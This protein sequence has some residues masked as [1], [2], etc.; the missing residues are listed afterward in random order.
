[1]EKITPKFMSDHRCRRREHDEQIRIDD[2][3]LSR[4]SSKMRQLYETLDWTKGCCSLAQSATHVMNASRLSHGRDCINTTAQ[5]G[6]LLRCCRHQ[7]EVD[8]VEGYEWEVFRSFNI[9]QWRPQVVIVEIEDEHDSFKHVKF[10]QRRSD[11]DFFR[12]SHV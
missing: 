8:H 1:M 4:C 11:K 9:S 10:L 5:F 12:S 2:S 7:T 3:M 6:V